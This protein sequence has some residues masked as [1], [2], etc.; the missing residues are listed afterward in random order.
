MSV[1]V[2]E[3]V[4]EPTP[5]LLRGVPEGQVNGIVFYPD[6]R[7]MKPSEEVPQELFG[8]QLDQL[9]SNMV[10]TMYMC[11][12]MGLSAVQIGMPLRVFVSDITALGA[13][14]KGNA[15]QLLVVINPVI[16]IPDGSKM[17]GIVEGC[18]SFPGVNEVVRR[19]NDVVLRARDRYGELYALS[20]D[21]M[22]GRIIQ[23]EMDHLNG[24]TFLDRMKP[25]AKQSA[26]KSIRAFHKGVEDDSIRVR[27]KPVVK[28][29][30]RRGR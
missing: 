2:I 3:R 14:V 13:Q 23:H 12:G 1:E 28:K 4:K 6:E 16:E 30:K 7:L 26:Q 18:L 10:T 15:N 17:V 24:K 21:G 5:E 20:I 9:V 19:A 11:G 29:N 25:M 27:S 22:L 8:E